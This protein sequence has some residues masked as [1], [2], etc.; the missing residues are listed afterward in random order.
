MVDLK[1]E[2]ETTLRNI[3]IHVVEII[4][5][6]VDQWFLSIEGVSMSLELFFGPCL[7]ESSNHQ[8]TYYF[9]HFKTTY[10]TRFEKNII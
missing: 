3:K 9:S 4:L 5:N 1:P 6:R 8:I 2:K 7:V 10:R